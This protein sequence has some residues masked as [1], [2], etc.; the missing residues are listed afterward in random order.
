MSRLRIDAMA[1]PDISRPEMDS[2]DT[3]FFQNDTSPP[4]QLPTPAFIIERYGDKGRCVVTIDELDMV[5]KINYESDLR[6]EEVQ[7]MRAIREMFLHHDVQVPVPEVFGWRRHGEQVFI[8]MSLIPGK[9]LRQAWP[10]LTVDDKKSIQRRLSQIVTAL[11][12]ITQENPNK[13]GEFFHEST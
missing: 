2:L 11:R 5:V 6:L 1:L 4:P 7:T 9:T 8:Y 10:D 3:S 13:I 12:Q